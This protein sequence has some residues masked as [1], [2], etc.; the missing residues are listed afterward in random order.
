M[1]AARIKPGAGASVGPLKLTQLDPP[2]CL[3]TVGN[4]STPSRLNLRFDLATIDGQASRY[5]EP[6]LLHLCPVTKSWES[7]PEMAP[8]CA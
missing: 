1:A 2:I 7:E 8:G 3:G 4:T 6:L 5:F